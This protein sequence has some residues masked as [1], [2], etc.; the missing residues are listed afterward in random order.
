[1]EIGDREPGVP[2]SLL[3]GVFEP[4]VRVD[5]ARTRERGGTQP[6]LAIA[7]GGEVRAENRAA[8][9]LRVIVILPLQ[10]PSL[11]RPTGAA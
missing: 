3:A 5:T 2:E 1:M 4:F 8:G 11:D 7:H 6:G 10:T 9:G